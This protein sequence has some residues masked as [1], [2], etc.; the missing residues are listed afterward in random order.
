[1]NEEKK[2]TARW[3]LVFP[4]VAVIFLLS[5]SVYYLQ[6]RNGDVLFM[7]QMY[8]VFMSGTEF[9]SECMSRPGG[10]LEWGGRWFT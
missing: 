5:A 4:A 8:S 1:M 9:F 6:L 3:H 7:A 10:L 2:T